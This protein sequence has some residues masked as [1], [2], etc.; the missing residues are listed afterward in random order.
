MAAALP[1]G[2]RHCVQIHAGCL[3]HERLPWMHRSGAG[4]R[5]PPPAWP[6]LLRCGRLAVLSV[7]D[8]REH[9]TCASLAPGDRSATSPRLRRL[10]GVR[11]GGPRGGRGSPLRRVGPHEHLR[12]Q[13]GNCCGFVVA[14]LVLPR[15]S[16]HTRG[17]AAAGSPYVSPAPPPRWSPGRNER[18]GAGWGGLWHGC[19]QGKQAQEA[20]GEA[21][22]CGSAVS[23]T[24]AGQRPLLPPRPLPR[25]D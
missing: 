1:V 23:L 14:E 25:G 2:R 21:N 18:R 4:K 10:P 5:Q 24:R 7:E 15:R 19:P 16:P 6:R 11:G 13:G 12:V 3:G 8:A 20:P 22:G 17:H 9:G